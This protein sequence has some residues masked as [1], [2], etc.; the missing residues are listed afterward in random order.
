MIV[1]CE[2]SFVGPAHVPFNAGMLTT[3]RA[4]FPKEDLAFYGAAKHVEELQ[5]QVGPRLA[6]SIAWREILPPESSTRYIKRFLRELSVIWRLLGILA[7]DSP[8]RLILT[9]AYPS[10]VLA[11]KVARWFQPKH[12]PVQIVLHGLSGVVGSRYRNPL[13]R[14]QDMRTALTLLGNNGI[15]YLFLE[16]SIRNAVLQNLPFL[17][18]NVEALEH[19]VAPNEGL[20]LSAELTQ[21]IRFG[22]LGLA[23]QAKGFPVFHELAKRI[24]A[25]HGSLAEFHA[26]GHLPKNGKLVLGLEALSTKP[27][28]TLMSREDYLEAVKMLHFIVL[29]HQAL[30]YN[31]TASGVLLDAITWEKPIIAR[32]IPIFEMMFERY[33]DIGYL[34][35]DDAELIGIAEEILQS[36]DKVRYQRQVLHLR[37]LRMSR[38]PESLAKIYQD[39]CRKSG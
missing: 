7:Q 10:A 36:T 26:I 5:K 32:T 29:P 15:Q 35:D 8:S 4:A 30:S 17:S 3:I 13:R 39:I 23:D 38:S 34:F 1:L 37:S 31:L 28:N 24:T 11:T 33:G 9:S 25:T 16:E 21:P 12:T 20:T 2:L 22:F 14:F 18:G 6:S 19:P 27:G